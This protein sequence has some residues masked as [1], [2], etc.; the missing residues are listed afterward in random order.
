MAATPVKLGEHHTVWP[1]AA[2]AGG[3]PG[4]RWR[5]VLPGVG[6]ILLTL[7]AYFPVFHGGYDWDDN[8]HFR[9]NTLMADAGGLRE[10][11]LNTHP[12]GGLLNYFPVTLTSFWLQYQMFGVASAAPYHVVSVCIHA[13]NVLLVWW[14][15][16]RLKIGW[17]WLAAA[18][19]AIHPLHVETV[20]WAA[21][22]KNLLSTLF[23]LGAA[24][25]FLS[26]LELQ[27]SPKRGRK[28]GCYVLALLLFLLAMLSK[29]VVLTFPAAMLLL[30]WW[31][32]GRVRWIDGALLLPFA[33][34]AVTIAM[35]FAQIDAVHVVQLKIGLQNTSLDLSPVQ[36]VLVAGRA[37]CFY[38]GKFLWPVEF[39]AIY[40]RWA[41]IG[42]SW[43]EYLYPLM[44]LMGLSALWWWRKKLTIVPL[45]G[46]IFF[47][48][49]LSPALGLINHAFMRYSYVANHF[50]YLANLGLI[51]CVVELLRVASSHLSSL[52]RRA[53]GVLAR[54][55]PQVVWSAVLILILTPLC[56][57]ESYLESNPI[58]K[59]Q[60]TVDHNPDSWTA[61]GMLAT[62]YVEQHDYEQA[63]REAKASATISLNPAALVVSALALQRQGKLA[64]SC[65]AYQLYVDHD[66]AGAADYVRYGELLAESGRFEKA[67]AMFQTAVDRDPRLV[68]GWDDLARC[69]LLFKHWSL[70]A[71]AEQHCLALMESFTARLNLAVALHGG[72][73]FSGAATE[74]RHAILLQP[75]SVEAHAGLMQVLF[76]LNDQEGGQHERQIVQ[77]LSGR[78][79]Q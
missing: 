15:L 67:L 59:W 28:W 30:I 51:V 54:W 57:G 41:N 58:A 2:L 7:L 45:V 56:I 21:E 36:R 34:V 19:F 76:L 18:L 65:S 20:A 6:L 27:E 13:L 29:A 4:G 35:L 52:T 9:D 31:K 26:F 47:V 60:Y 66:W 24:G 16:S 11:W 49:T 1:G 33:V 46:A 62:A 42:A 71:D 79:A 74:Y 8:I 32:K 37:L 39:L 43:W 73:N 77:A 68:N 10:I 48:L 17:S 53:G 44:A 14:L 12:P 78:K 70:A 38:V 3:L 72:G 23:Y 40:P 55:Q 61:H 75:N 25:G 64:E 63:L 5:L 22:Q 50:T 69:H